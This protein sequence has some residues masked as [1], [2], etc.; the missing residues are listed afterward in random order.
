MPP[1]TQEWTHDLTY[2]QQSV[3]L[4]VLRG[5]DTLYKYHPSKTILRWLRRCILVSAFDGKVM[6]DPYRRG[7]GTFMGPIPGHVKIDMVINNYFEVID[8]VPHHFQLHL[9]HA[10]EILGYKHPD[11]DIRGWWFKL[12][13]FFVDDMHLQRESEKEMDD[14]LNY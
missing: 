8:E 6:D 14:R 1:V 2:M 9:M 13:K 10:S 3:L 4:S 12:Y 11:P 5:P 7:G